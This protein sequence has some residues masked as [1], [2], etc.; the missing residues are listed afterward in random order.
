MGVN[1]APTFKD[2]KEHIET[3]V[4]YKVYTAE[5]PADE[6]L[7]FDENGVMDP[8]VVVNFGGPVRAAKDRGLVSAKHDATILF[9]TLDCYAARE[10]D[11]IEIKGYLV[12][13]LTGWV[14]EGA[15]ELVPMG[16]MTYSR[17]SNRV[18]PTQYIEATS[19]QCFS[20]LS[21]V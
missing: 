11:A 15:T 20:N 16:G 19:F 14:P 3:L 21:S 9:I 2:I 6:A 7:T 10:W 4:E 8:F 5:I 18:R 12:E 13:E 1:P 17:A